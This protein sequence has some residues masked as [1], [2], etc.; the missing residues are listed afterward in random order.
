MFNHNLT[1]GYSGMYAQTWNTHVLPELWKGPREWTQLYSMDS[2]LLVTSHDNVLMCLKMSRTHRNI[3]TGKDN[4][5]I[6]DTTDFNALSKQTTSS[7][8]ESNRVH[9]SD[10]KTDRTLKKSIV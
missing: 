7:S 6:S 9:T 4:S 5:Y 3:I 10:L 2:R 8:K 1:C